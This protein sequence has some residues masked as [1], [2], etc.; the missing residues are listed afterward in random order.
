MDGICKKSNTQ[1]YVRTTIYVWPLSLLRCSLYLLLE[2]TPLHVF[3]FSVNSS[4]HIPIASS[5]KCDMHSLS[6]SLNHKQACLYIML[7]SVLHTSLSQRYLDW[8]FFFFVFICFFLLLLR[9]DSVYVYF[10]LVC[11]S[12]GFFSLIIFSFNFFFVSLLIVFYFVSLLLLCD[13][14]YF[15]HQFFLHSILSWS[16]FFFVLYKKNARVMCV[17]SEINC[18]KVIIMIIM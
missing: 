15:P 12:V 7:I 18:E 10:M 11:V 16:N 4:I 6:F 9:S 5:P 13:T 8:I 14:F 3:F 1:T 2:T 17:K